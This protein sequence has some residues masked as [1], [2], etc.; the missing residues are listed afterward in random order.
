MLG[1]YVLCLA[2]AYSVF[3]LPAEYKDVIAFGILV[4]ILVLR[5]RGLLGEVVSERA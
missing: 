1:G 2:E 4:L 3:F 5:P